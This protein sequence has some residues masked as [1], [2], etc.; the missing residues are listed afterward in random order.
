MPFR[1]RA[2]DRAERWM[3][4]RL[5]GSDGLGAI[6]PSIM[7]TVL[8]LVCRGRGVDDPLVRSQLH[9]LE[10]LEIAD[11]DEL[12]LQPCLSPV[13]DTSLALNSLLEC[14][15]S[16]RTIRRSS[17]ARAGCSSARCAAPATGSTRIP[18]AEP[19]GW[20]FEYANEFYPDCDDTA[21]VLA[22]LDRIPFRDAESEE[23]PSRRARSGARVA[24]LDAVEERRLGGVR[25]GL[26][27]PHSRA[28]A[29]RR[30]Q[31][32][33]RSGH[34]R[35]HLAHDRGADRHGPPGHPIRPSVAPSRSC[36][37]SRKS[38][39][40]GTGAGAPTTSTAP[41][42]R[43]PRCAMSARICAAP[44][45]AVA[46]SGCS[47]VRTRTAAG[48]SRCSPTRIRARRVAARPRRRRRRGPSSA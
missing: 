24:P 37:R 20:Y 16:R 30:P 42:S 2:L 39:G 5:Q 22:L 7:N 17:A 41:G 10:K 6:F 12:R 15:V 28:G 34:R 13:W 23:P 18:A 27:P 35:R 4:E 8:A 25:Q 33:A 44:A 38:R 11:G 26:R 43:S 36:G 40:A 9:E 29:V 21:E 3:I 46:S 45:F 31:R 48:A 47:P 1:A 19:G 32:D 14:G